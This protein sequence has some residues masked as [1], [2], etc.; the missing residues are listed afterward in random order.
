MKQTIRNLRKIIDDDNTLVN[1]KLNLAYLSEIAKKFNL[2]SD[3]LES[4]NTPQV[5]YLVEHFNEIKK[6][7]LS[8]KQRDELIK[9]PVEI[10][11][12]IKSNDLEDDFHYFN[13][14]SNEISSDSIEKLEKYVNSEYYNF[15]KFIGVLNPR[16]L[17]SFRNYFI[18]NSF[19]I[20]LFFSRCIDEVPQ[21]I[22]DELN[23]YMKVNFNLEKFIPN[24]N[25]KFKF[26]DDFWEE[27]K[28]SFPILY[29]LFN[30]CK[31]ISISNAS[32]ERSFSIYRAILTDRRENLKEEN[33]I[34]FTM[35][36]FNN[37]VID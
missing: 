7:L 1:L 14:I 2:V 23:K 35:Y 26:L 25:L 21:A 28:L 10:Q 6:L 32:V 11:E 3:L 5:F 9:W 18:S 36:Y 16:L 31:I 24:E 4:T 20:S 19:G 27:F 22:F 8:F 15:M 17:N 29:K 13:E 30:F 33:L 12:T 37:R 34:F